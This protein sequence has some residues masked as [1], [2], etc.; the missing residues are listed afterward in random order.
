MARETSSSAENV[1][2][3]IF[4]GATD[5]PTVDVVVN[6]G[7]TLAEAVGYGESS[8]Y[9][10]VEGKAYLIVLKNAEDG[11]NIMGFEVKLRDYRGS[12]AVILASGFANPAANQGGKALALLGVLPDGSVVEFPDPPLSVD[13]LDVANV[14]VSFT[15]EQNYPNPF[16]PTTTIRFGLPGEAFVKLQVFNL[17]GQEVAR[18][19]NQKMEAGAHKIEF[20]AKSL[21]SGTYIYRIQADNFNAIRKMTLLK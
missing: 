15:L 10:S 2:F 11:S 21:N 16:N 12:A 3:F 13:E 14:P 6:R 8:D 5:A 4:H 20:D 18:L 19:L 7:P 9:L 17:L 1:D